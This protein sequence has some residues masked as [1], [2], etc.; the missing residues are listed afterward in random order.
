MSVFKHFFLIALITTNTCATHTH[1]RA[2]SDIFNLSSFV[3]IQKMRYEK[4]QWDSFFGSA[5]A[6]RQSVWKKFPFPPIVMLEILGLIKN[7]YYSE[8]LEISLKLETWLKAQ[9]Q[10]ENKYITKLQKLEAII[11]A[12]ETLKIKTSQK[13]TSVDHLS[14]NEIL[15][16]S[17]FSDL[18]KINPTNFRIK[19]INRCK[20]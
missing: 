6:Y 13:N 14:T 18:E 12:V 8:A 16:P 11:P 2:E 10:I 4:K 20:R 7:C 1:G 5:Q 3:K 9:N 15:W 19:M 17:H